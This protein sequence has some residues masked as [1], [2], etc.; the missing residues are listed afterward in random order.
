ADAADGWLVPGGGLA[1]E[2]DSRCV[3][4]A[5]AELEGRFTG[6]TVRRDLAGRERIVYA[7]KGRSMQR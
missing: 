2:L 6:V 7:R 5:A 4:A 3:A 1:L